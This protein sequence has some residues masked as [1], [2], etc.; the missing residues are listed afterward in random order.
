MKL[1]LS[2]GAA[3]LL[4][5]VGLVISGM[6][7]ANRV[8]GF[9][10][11]A[12]GWDATLA[13]VM[14]GAIAVHFVMF[15][16][17]TRRKSPILADTFAVPT[18]TNMTPQLIVGSVL[19]GVGWAFSGYCPGPG[20]VSLPSGGTAAA[21]FMGTM[22]AGMVGYHVWQRAAQRLRDRQSPTTPTDTSSAQPHVT[23]VTAQANP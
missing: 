12:G 13:F 18:R 21:V 19:F 16:L 2:A 22:T 17:V 5:G 7:D 9:L 15:R 8:I 11:L 1:L 14:I 6:T 23:R 3:G 10:D 4:F 20:L